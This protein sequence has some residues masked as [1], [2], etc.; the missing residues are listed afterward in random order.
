LEA[1]G[2]RLRRQMRRMGEPE[3]QVRTTRSEISEVTWTHL[4]AL[5]ERIIDGTKD[6]RLRSVLLEIWGETAI[7]HGWLASWVVDVGDIE[8][9]LVR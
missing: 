5:Y 9:D 6:I 2:R 1:H 7:E 3:V 4:F 8:P